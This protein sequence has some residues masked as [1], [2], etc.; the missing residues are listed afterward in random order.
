MERSLKPIEPGNATTQV[1]PALEPVAGPARRR[2]N[3][4]ATTRVILALMLRE[5]STR[6]GRT[7]GGYIWAIVEPVSMIAVLAFGFSLITRNPPLGNSFIL[8][9][10]SGLLAFNQYRDLE[11]VVT[12]AL[13]YAQGLLKFPVVTWLD[14]I[15]ARFILNFLT[16]VL[17]TILIMWGMIQIAD[18]STMIDLGP[19]V[20]AMC[21]ASFLGLGVGVLN[22][23]LIGLWPIWNTVYGLV[24]RPLLLASA[25]FYTMEDLPEGIADLLWFNPLVHITGLMRAGVFSTYDPQYVSVP[26]VLGFALV[27]MATGLVFLR[28]YATTILNAH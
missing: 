19:M 12:R 5:M 23:L 11:I 26:Y 16:S 1:L 17:N 7:P 28:R 22:A 24:N 8:F 21:L 3:M 25:I 4:L 15:L 2:N 6:Y 14:A 27:S 10:A 9:Y 18:V 13:P 20:E